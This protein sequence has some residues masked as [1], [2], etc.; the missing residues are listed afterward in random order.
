MASQLQLVLSNMAGTVP[1]AQQQARAQ[2]QLDWAQQQHQQAQAQQ[3]LD[4]ARLG[5]VLPTK[6]SKGLPTKGSKGQGGMCLY[7]CM[8][9][10]FVCV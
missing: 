10:V 8:L 7:V 1:L 3:Q 4:W 2:Q 9:K 5:W 6:G